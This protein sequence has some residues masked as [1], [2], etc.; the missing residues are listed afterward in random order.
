[1][2]EGSP[3]TTRI[4]RDLEETR[5]RLDATIGALQQKLSPGQLLDQSLAYLKDSGGGEFAHNLKSNVQTN[6]LPVALV[7]IGLA[8]LMM[9]G[10]GRA[11]PAQQP[12]RLAGGHEDLASGDWAGHYGVDAISRAEA[13][14]AGVRRTASETAEAFQ[15]R[16]YLAKGKA[17]GVGRNV[18]EA[19]TDFG[20][21]V[22]AA[23][24]QA[25]TSAGETARSLRHAAGSALDTTRDATGRATGA[26]RDAADRAAGFLQDQPLVTGAIGVSVGALLAAL[27]PPS[28]AEDELLGGIGDK[29]K[30][31][32]Y[33]A[34]DT[35]IAGGMRVADEV[36]QAGSETARREGLTA[37]NAD[38]AASR[39]GAEVA[40]AAP[41]ARHVVEDA[42]AAGR[43]AIDRELRQDDGTSGGRNGPSRA[44]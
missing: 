15:E 22:D 7:G 19:L 34:A 30:E 42:L 35:A 32:A 28:R 11:A 36:V 25:R 40:G 33:E 20:S 2:I 16:L 8:W 3:E 6:P 39:A 21:R 38:D 43:D 23:M 31:R 17:L 26:A 4:E 13:A 1:M 24:Q 9:G 10:H 44:G 41:S 27:L 37:D 14:A 18:G 5:A 12:T 29:L